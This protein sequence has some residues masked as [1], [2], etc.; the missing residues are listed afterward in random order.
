MRISS[1]IA[2][3]TSTPLDGA[4]QAKLVDAAQQFEATMLQELL[5][6]MQHGQ[7]SWGDEEK[8][9]DSSTDS[10]SSFGT[11]AVAKAISK[12][13]GFGIAKQIV[14]KVTLEHQRNSEK[15]TVL[16]LKFVDSRPIESSRRRLT[17]SYTSGIGSLQ[18]AINPIA[19]AETKPAT[20]AITPN[21]DELV[22]SVEHTDE[23]NLSSAGGIVAQALEGSDV[24]TAKV[25]ALQQ[26]IAD[27]SY[28]V[29]S[30]DVAEKI[31]QSLLD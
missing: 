28:N 15:T 10:I 5:K 21:G 31:I 17:M 9:D 6:P 14:S 24:R 8:S 3:N 4:K 23:T 19:S 27:G 30:S 2:S 16:V 13:G 1:D 22:A 26:A 12:G 29:S 18:Q 7:S 20:T 11:E 25:A